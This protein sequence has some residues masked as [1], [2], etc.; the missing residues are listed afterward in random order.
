MGLFF[1]NQFLVL[2][3]RK[4]N[5]FFRDEGEKIGLSLPIW[6]LLRAASNHSKDKIF[7]ENVI[8]GFFKRYVLFDQ[9]LTT[10]HRI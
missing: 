2:Q 5:I 9:D 4:R 7:F 3:E 1:S 6:K 8:S 10:I